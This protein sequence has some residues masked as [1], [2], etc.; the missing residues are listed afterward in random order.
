MSEPKKTTWK[1][2]CAELQKD[3]EAWFKANNIENP[4]FDAKMFRWLKGHSG[5]YM[6]FYPEEIQGS[7]G[8]DIYIESVN[9]FTVPELRK[10]ADEIGH[11]L[12]TLYRWP[13]NKN[14]ETYDR[15]P[16]DARIIMVPVSELVT[17]FNPTA[18]RYIQ[19]QTKIQFE[20]E[21][22]ETKST[23]KEEFDT[24]MDPEQDMSLDQMT[25]RDKMA[26]EHWVPCSCKKWLNS[27][28]LKYP[29]G[30]HS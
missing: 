5:L 8:R 25:V 13:Y 29:E 19:L 21:I 24:I 10:D 23:L 2:R 16:K 18:E 15:D 11:P 28:I 30:C 22:S 20:N 26:I 9:K 1:T 4:Y 12:R 7:K 27:I 14:W 17:E 3:H 6:G